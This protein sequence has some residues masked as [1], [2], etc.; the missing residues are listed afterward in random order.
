M[1]YQKSYHEQKF[2]TINDKRYNC[3][4]LRWIPLLESKGHTHT[5]T[6]IFLTHTDVSFVP[7]TAICI[8]ML[9]PIPPAPSCTVTW[10]LTPPPPAGLRSVSPLRHDSRQRRGVMD[11]W[12][13]GKTG[14][15]A[16]LLSDKEANTTEVRQMESEFSPFS[17]PDPP[18]HLMRGCGPWATRRPGG[19]AVLVTWRLISF[20]GNYSCP[21]PDTDFP[22]AFVSTVVQNDLCGAG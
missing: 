19:E 1:I 12:R 15:A 13:W 4:S 2:I 17:I 18:R 11:G 8:T 9:E 21:V 22:L 5:P 16:G 3:P 7:L 10:P 6:Y 14:E 20:A